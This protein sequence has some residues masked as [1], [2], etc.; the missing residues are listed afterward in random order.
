M[1]ELNDSFDVISNC[2][3][4]TAFNIG[5]RSMSPNLIVCDEL[6]DD[7]VIYLNEVAV[8]GVK[9]FASVHADSLNNAIAKLNLNKYNDIFERF[10]L[11]SDKNGVGTI[12]GVYDNKQNKLL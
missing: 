1:F 2:G 11:L 3:K 7:D 10:V 9:V 8:S 12:E 4:K 6:V 5:I